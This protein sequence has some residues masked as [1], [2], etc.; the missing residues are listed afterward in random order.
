[1]S[2]IIVLIAAAAVAAIAL[3]LLVLVYRVLTVHVG[4]NVPAAEAHGETAHHFT[5]QRTEPRPTPP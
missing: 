3:V 5:D 4:P 1:V 2:L